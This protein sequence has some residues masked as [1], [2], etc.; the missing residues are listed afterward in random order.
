MPIEM[1]DSEF[2]QA[3]RSGDS[4]AFKPL[5]ERYQQLVFRTAMGFLHQQEEAE[6]LTQD[7][8]IRAWQSIDN[9]SG[10]A[11]F[12]TWLYKITVNQCLNHLRRKKRQEFF[13]F[14]EDL[15]DQLI[16]KVSEEINPDAQVEE[17]ERDQQIKA[18]IDS[19]SEKQRTAFVLSRYEELPQKEIAHIMNTSE[20]AVEQHLQR[21]RKSLQK[22]LAFLVG[23]N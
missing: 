6:D 12:S 4:N 11:A 15:F 3:V 14:A 13:S 7:I 5:V 21:A 9:Y 20:G 17:N 19:L 16:N 2:I 18:A 10:D 22:K 1:T 8:F 23:K